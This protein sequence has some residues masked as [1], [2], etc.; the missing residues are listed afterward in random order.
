MDGWRKI[1]AARPRRHHGS[2]SLDPQLA[3]TLDDLGQRLVHPE[4]QMMKTGSAVLEKTLDRT[5]WAGRLDQLEHLGRAEAPDCHAAR[6][7][8][9]QDAVVEGPE[10]R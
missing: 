5:S 2:D 10:E 4:R 9:Q 7:L 3:E 8:G 6:H 1:E